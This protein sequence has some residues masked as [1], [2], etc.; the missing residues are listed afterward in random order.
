MVIFGL[1]VAT[2]EEFPMREPYPTDKFE[3]LRKELPRKFQI[4]K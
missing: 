4:S 3:G 2:L 1:W